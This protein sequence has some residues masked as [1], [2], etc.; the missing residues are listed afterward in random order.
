MSG[1]EAYPLFAIRSPADVG[2]QLVQ[3]VRNV[4]EGRA[5]EHGLLQVLDE[6]GIYEGSNL[7]RAPLWMLKSPYR[8][9]VIGQHESC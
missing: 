2:A 7:P 1:L 5:P 6:R 9:C 3:H 4:A 8:L